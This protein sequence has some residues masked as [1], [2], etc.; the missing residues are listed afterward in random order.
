MLYIYR[1]SLWKYLANCLELQWPS[2]NVSYTQRN[3]FEI[4]LNQTEIRLYLPFSDWFGT[5]NGLCLFAFPNQSEDSKYNL[6]SVWFNNI[7]KIFLSVYTVKL[8][9]NLTTN[10]TD[11]LHCYAICGS[12]KCSDKANCCQLLL[13]S[14]YYWTFNGHQVHWG[15]IR[16]L[17]L[18]ASAIVGG[19]RGSN[20][21]NRNVVRQITKFGIIVFR[22][23]VINISI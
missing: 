2:L 4:L 10:Y 17:N 21:A 16:A 7:S 19:S 12:N 22:K 1:L 9:S 8:H 3:L 15:K 14:N 13:L 18:Y 20:K 5:S 23:I 11:K 6:I